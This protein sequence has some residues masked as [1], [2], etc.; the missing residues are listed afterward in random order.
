MAK[1]FDFNKIKR[2]YMTVKLRDGKTLVVRMPEKRV[3]EKMQDMSE[4]DDENNGDAYRYLLELVAEILSNNKNKEMVTA[5][6]LEE[7]GYDIE[8]LTAFLEEY[9]EFTNQLKNDPN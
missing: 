6:Y 3:F 2:S 1:L 4:L 8:E 9:G 7:E 5:Q